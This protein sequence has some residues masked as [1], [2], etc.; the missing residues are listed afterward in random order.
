MPKLE[1]GFTESD[2]DLPRYLRK[3]IKEHVDGRVRRWLEDR[4]MNSDMP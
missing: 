4:N 3:M 1:T 2:T